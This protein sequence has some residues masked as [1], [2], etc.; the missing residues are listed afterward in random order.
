MRR[1]TCI[2]AQVKTFPFSQRSALGGYF[3]TELES[4]SWRSSGS[5]QPSLRLLRDTYQDDGSPLPQCVQYVMSLWLFIIAKIQII[6]NG[7]IFYKWEQI[8]TMTSI[9]FVLW[10]YKS[11]WYAGNCPWL[12]SF[13]ISYS[14]WWLYTLREVYLACEE[15]T[16]Y[17][18]GVKHGQAMLLSNK[19]EFFLI[20]TIFLVAIKDYPMRPRENYSR[21]S[22][23]TFIRCNVASCSAC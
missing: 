22:S 18:L 12:I 6:A 1:L 10:F 11:E 21:A 2:S 14:P 17:V 13:H 23:D 20:W 9:S 5:V 19:K 15:N 16:F 7:F 4:S 8:Q 3:Q